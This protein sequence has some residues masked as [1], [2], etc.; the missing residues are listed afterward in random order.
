MGKMSRP[1]CKSGRGKVIW[2][3]SCRSRVK[4]C[5]SNLSSQ[6]RRRCKL[7][8]T[9]VEVGGNVSRSLSKSKLKAMQVEVI[10]VEVEGN[11]SRSYPSWSQRQ[12]KSKLSKSNIN[13]S[14]RYSHNILFYTFYWAPDFDLSPLH[15][16][17]KKLVSISIH[18]LDNAWVWQYH[19]HNFDDDDH[20]ID[21][22]SLIPIP[23]SY[24][25]FD[26]N[27][28]TITSCPTCYVYLLEI[29]W[30]ISFVENKYWWALQR[31]RSW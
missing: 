9:Q 10:Q 5:N 29:C 21:L 14:N 19:M 30:D 1:K 27:S 26:I 15:L 20:N 12:H 28:N 25:L 6:G 7:K 17:R 4:K 11:A 8:F 13:M 2:P 18:C 16:D 24:T 31:L 22:F 3:K 23:T